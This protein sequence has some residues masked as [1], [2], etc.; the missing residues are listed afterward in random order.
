MLP[1]ESLPLSPDRRHKQGIARAFSRA[2]AHYDR[3]A[4]FQR[5]SGQQ[6]MAMMGD[7]RGKTVLDAGC[8]TGW[9]SQQWQQRGNPVIA[10]DL[11]AAMIGQARQRC[12]AG[13][14][15]LGDL[16]S[17]PLA[18]ACVDIAFSNLAIQWCD[19][20]P[21]VLAELTRV[22]RP[23]GMIGISTLARGSLIELEQAWQQ[24]DQRCHSN[25]FLTAARIRRAFSGY[26]HRLQ[27]QQ[28]T[29]HYPDLSALLHEIKGVGAGYL[30]QGRASGLT[31]RQRLRALDRAWPRHPDGLPLTYQLIYG[32][33]YCD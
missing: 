9:F 29:L 15:L 21:R 33:I 17:L 22:V 5:A 24:V 23:G 14:Y 30:R 18:D 26:R 10:L 20:L 4:A 28:H 3:Y 1:I 7:Q 6:L 8:G 12:S 16:E 2:A 11:S 25:R 32:V 19:D 31:G 13:H 27:P